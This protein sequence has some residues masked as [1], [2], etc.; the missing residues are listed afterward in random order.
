M[1]PCSLRSEQTPIVFKFVGYS[2]ASGATVFGG[3]GI[4]AGAAYGSSL[5]AQ[6]TEILSFGDFIGT[7]ALAGGEVG[8]LAGAGVG[9]AVG[10]LAYGGYELYEH[11][12]SQPGPQPVNKP[13]N[14]TGASGGG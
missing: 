1:G 4:F 2:A 9:V 12:N 11:L 14:S 5:I 8:G 7:G 10:L 3:I 13:P 6:S